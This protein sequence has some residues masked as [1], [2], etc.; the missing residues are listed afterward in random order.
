MLYLCI[1]LSDVLL[2]LSQISVHFTQESLLK[3]PLSSVEFILGSLSG[4]VSASSGCS[5]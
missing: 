4:W 1:Y 5:T 3:V 2:I